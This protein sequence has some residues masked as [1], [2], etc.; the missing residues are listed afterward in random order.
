MG[1]VNVVAGGCRGSLLKRF[2]LFSYLNHSFIFSLN[3]KFVLGLLYFFRF[4]FVFYLSILEVGRGVT[5]L[6]VGGGGIFAGG[7]GGLSTPL[8]TMFRSYLNCIGLLFQVLHCS[9]IPS[10]FFY[11]YLAQSD[12]C[13]LSRADASFC[14]HFASNLFQIWLV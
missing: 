2:A 3:V 8:H 1:G 5:D 6:G 4:H 11:V 10:L 12:Q 7:D 9:E 14:L 13:L